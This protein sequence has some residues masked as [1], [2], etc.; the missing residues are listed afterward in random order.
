MNYTCFFFLLHR[1]R[2]F[3]SSHEWTHCSCWLRIARQ[4]Q[5][6]RFTSAHNAL[7]KY[8]R[9]CFFFFVS[10]VVVAIANQPLDARPI[11]VINAMRH[12]GPDIVCR[13]ASL[14]SMVTLM[15]DGANKRCTFSIWIAFAS[16]L[17]HILHI[18]ALSVCRWIADKVPKKKEQQI[19]INDFDRCMENTSRRITSTCCAA[20]HA[21]HNHSEWH[22]KKVRR[23]H[24]IRV[25][26]YELW[27][28]VCDDSNDSS[29]SMYLIGGMQF[30]FARRPSE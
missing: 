20:R 19:W 27:W 15:S 23:A 10:F 2:V 22:T 3:R 30:Y 21:N 6:V 16:E 4:K 13:H 9:F 12:T 26:V 25:Y 8:F 29:K 17:T 24:D 11:R 1:D 18:R 5:I 14:A 7:A 28:L